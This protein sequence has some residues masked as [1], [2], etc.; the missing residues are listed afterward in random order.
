M[1][2]S[3]EDTERVADAVVTH[4]RDHPKPFYPME[5][6]ELAIGAVVQLASGGPAMTVVEL[7]HDPKLDVTAEV[8]TQWFAENDLRTEYFPPG[9]LKIP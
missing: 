1:P 4:Y 7:V 8:K 9:C 6:K 5:E 2:F 3:Q